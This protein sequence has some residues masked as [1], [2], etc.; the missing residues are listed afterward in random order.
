MTIGSIIGS[1]P[2]QV[3]GAVNTIGES[4]INGAKQAGTFISEHTPQSI[5]NLKMS[6][7]DEFISSAKEKEFVKNTGDFVKTNKNTIAGI[8]VV[9]AALG[10]AFSIIKGVANKIKEAKAEKLAMH[11]G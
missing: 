11:Q 6:H 8:L 3:K 5:K 10:S 9:L 1:I 7:V 2:S 4:T